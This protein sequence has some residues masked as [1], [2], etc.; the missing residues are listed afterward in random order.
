MCVVELITVQMFDTDRMDL[1]MM[2]AGFNQVF[3]KSSIAVAASQNTTVFISV[4]NDA[5]TLDCITSESDEIH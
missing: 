5:E 4:G 1:V 3:I 2:L